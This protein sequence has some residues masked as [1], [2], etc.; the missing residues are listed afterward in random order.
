VTRPYSDSTLV[1]VTL[2]GAKSG[3][4]MT[5]PIE[6]MLDGG[7]LIVFGTKGGAP[8]D[9][10]WVHNLR[11][12]PDV[13]VEYGADRFPAVAQEITGAERDRLWRQ[14]VA[15]KP[16]FAKYTEQTDRV[17]PAFALDRAG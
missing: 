7:R 10:A 12:N 5:L 17:F 15:D 14:L 8:T 13:V 4:E 16:R 11:A 2:R 9:P 1:L 3:R 6:Y